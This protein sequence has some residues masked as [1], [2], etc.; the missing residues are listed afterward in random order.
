MAMEMK[1]EMEMAIMDLT[2]PNH[3]PNPPFVFFMNVNVTARLSRTSREWGN[4]C[5]SSSTTMAITNSVSVR[6]ATPKR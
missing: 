3:A 4:R 5:R 1:M 6:F 2:P